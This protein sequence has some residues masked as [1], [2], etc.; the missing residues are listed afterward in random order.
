MAEENSVRT[1]LMRCKNCNGELTINENKN[2]ILCP[3]CGSKE[4]I[5]ESDTVRAAQ[6]HSQAYLNVEMTRMENQ[7]R[8]MQMERE[9]EERREKKRITTT[10]I[11]FGL[12]L[13]GWVFLLLP[14]LTGD[15]FYEYLPTM[16]PII[17]IIIAIIFF[18]AG[19]KVGKM[20]K[21]EKK[22]RGE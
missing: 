16:A 20:Y 17:S 9:R 14:F 4:I 18:V 2:L 13:L 5:L 1:I 7:M 12:K 3:Y 21:K 19:G 11:G 6:I 10:W 15:F 22:N 8:V